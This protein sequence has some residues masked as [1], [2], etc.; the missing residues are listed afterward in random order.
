MTLLAAILQIPAV[1]WAAVL[2]SALTLGGVTASNWSNTKRLRMQLQHDAEE[3]AKQ[4]K[5]ELRRDVYL[6]AAEELVKANAHLSRIP[7]LDFTKVN[8]SEGLLG[9]FAAAAKL[10]MV[11]EEKTALHVMDLV[12]LYGELLLKI[13]AS[14]HP[15]QVSQIDIAILDNEYE[16]TQTEIKRLLAAMALQSESGTAD[17]KVFAALNQSFTF[18]HQRS[19]QI[20]KERAES[21]RQRNSAQM[22][23][24][25][26]FM[27]QMKIIGE[28]GMLLMVAIRRELEIGGNV[29]LFMTQIESQWQRASALLDVFLV[30]LEKR[31]AADS[32][33]AT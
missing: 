26:E 19:E 1:V 13:L 9:F 10:Q 24:L 14:A 5:A 7:H 16:N 8:P 23:F 4:R 18:H 29:D 17:Q 3:K 30:D 25:R 21:W 31:I 22:S 11:A 12:G 2:A 28:N 20:A 6:S 32:P 33:T 15:V 27:P